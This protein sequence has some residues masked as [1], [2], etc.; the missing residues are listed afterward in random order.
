MLTAREERHQYLLDDRLLSDDSLCNLLAKRA[1]GREQLFARGSCVLFETV[2][3]AIQA[4]SL[5]KWI[6][7]RQP[8][9]EMH[10]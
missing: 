4:N 3:S 10:E 2:C 5:F 7:C 6:D 8:A 1:C 9:Q